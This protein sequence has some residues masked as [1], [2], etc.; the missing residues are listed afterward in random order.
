MPPKAKFTKDEIIEAA[1]SIVRSEGIDA[2][3]ARALGAKLRSS[4]RPIFTVFKSMEEI[5]QEVITKSKKLY[6]EYIDHGLNQSEIPAFKGVGV[7]YINFA[8]S[9]PKLFQILFMS[10]YMEK[11][12]VSN[13]L[14]IIDDNYLQI[15]DSV[16][17]CFSLDQS[18]SEWLYRHLWIYS[19]G[20]AVLCATSMCS[21]SAEE[22]GKM[23]TE[24]CMSMVKSIKEKNI[25]D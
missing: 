22:I 4:A 24:V 10:E 13:I 18:D 15:L 21:F 25:N 23:L 19:H 12:S 8:I 9:E 1:F 17:K 20:I 5:H 16:K 7:E 3:T 14:P 2:L 6:S 11:P